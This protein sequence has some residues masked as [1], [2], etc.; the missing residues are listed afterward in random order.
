MTTLSLRLTVIRRAVN[1]GLA[2]LKTTGSMAF[3]PTRGIYSPTIAVLAEH[4][5]TSERSHPSADGFD[6]GV[7]VAWFSIFGTTSVGDH[8]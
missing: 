1:Y 4:Y 3:Y 7:A 6:G 5:V 8:E 2:N